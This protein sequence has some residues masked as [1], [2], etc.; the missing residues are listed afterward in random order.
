M[1]H[2]LRQLNEMIRAQHSTKDSQCSIALDTHGSIHV[3]VCN[4]NIP[5]LS[6]AQALPGELI[7][8]VYKLKLSAV[9]CDHTSNIQHV[10]CDVVIPAAFQERFPV[11]GVVL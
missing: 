8:I 7:S 11:L 9:H 6:V 3:C 1:S 2:V 4:S 10:S 5:F